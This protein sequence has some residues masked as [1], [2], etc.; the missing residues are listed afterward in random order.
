MPIFRILWGNTMPKILI[1]DDEEAIRL[2]LSATLSEIEYEVITADNVT[3]FWNGSNR[4]DPILSCWTLRWSI[5]TGSTFYRTF[6]TGFTTFL[7]YLTPPMMLSKKTLGLV[8][9]TAT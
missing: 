5:T 3:G 6:E 7:L 2:I 1:V 9:P 4:K 8:K